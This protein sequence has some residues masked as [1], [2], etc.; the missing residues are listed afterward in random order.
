MC[1]DWFK[2]RENLELGTGNSL[3]HMVSKLNSFMHS[4][5]LDCKDFS[6]GKKLPIFLVFDLRL[7]RRNEFFAPKDGCRE[8]PNKPSTLQK[9]SVI[10]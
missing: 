7:L 5:H 6:K 10:I 9:R 2:N 1:S 4:C 3:N 8:D